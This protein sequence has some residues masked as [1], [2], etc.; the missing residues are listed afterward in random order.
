MAFKKI[1]SSSEAGP[2]REENVPPS[3]R[4]VS[5][6]WLRAFVADRQASVNEPRRL[7]IEQGDRARAH[8]EAGRWGR[9]EMPDMEIPKVSPYYFLNTHGLVSQFVAP[10][11]QDI[12]G[13]LFA[14]LP[15]EH[16][17]RPTAFIS[18]TWK[19]LLIGPQRQRIGT[20]DAA[21]QEKDELVWI[22]FACYN[23]HTVR[24]QRHLRRYARRHQDDR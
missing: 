16:R 14:L 22:D 12:R 5:L 17:G 2:W 21:H 4:G 15:P 18:H 13:P 20:L 24:A 9:H 3:E 23:Q 7:A 6:H 11:T 8:N 19:S 10:L 1:L